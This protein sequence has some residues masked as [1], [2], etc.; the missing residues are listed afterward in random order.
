MQQAGWFVGICASILLGPIVYFVARLTE[1]LAPPR[2]PVPIVVRVTPP[3]RR[4]R[5]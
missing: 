5:A 2:V 1:V 4:P 3:L